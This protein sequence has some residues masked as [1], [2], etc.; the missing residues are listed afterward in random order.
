L[1]GFDVIGL[2]TGATV[3]ITVT[4]PIRADQ[5][6]KLQSGTWFQQQATVNDTAIFTLTDGATGDEDGSAKG[7][8]TDPGGPAVLASLVVRFAG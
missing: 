2:I 5:Y 3:T 1:L 6:W 4:L 7:T 8:I